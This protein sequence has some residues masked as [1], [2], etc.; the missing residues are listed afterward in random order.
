MTNSNGN[1][2]RRSWRRR[3][4]KNTHLVFI[5]SDEVITPIQVNSVSDLYYVHSV[6]S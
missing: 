2:D 4:K 1:K 6:I 3:K 5:H